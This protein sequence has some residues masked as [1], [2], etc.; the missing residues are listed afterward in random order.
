MGPASPRSFSDAG[1]TFAYSESDDD[2]KA[3]ASFRTQTSASPYPW[4][5]KAAAGGDTP[6]GA[7]A[8]NFGGSEAG[9]RPPSY[10]SK[11]STLN[12]VPSSAVRHFHLC[13]FSWK[14]V[15]DA[16]V[17]TLVSRSGVPSP[18]ASRPT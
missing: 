7:V 8:I 15:A 10:I 4:E 3:D 9:S 18:S 5:K 11:G 17:W 13:S 1:S 2:E 12:L 14:E 6:D 16:M